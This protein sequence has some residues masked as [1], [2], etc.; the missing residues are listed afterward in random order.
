MKNQLFALIGLGLLLAT[1]SAYAQTGVVK[2]NV[3]FNF[4]VE[5]TQIPAGEYLIQNLG[6]SGSAMTIESPDRKLVKL[7]LP[8][9]C[10]STQA[11]E[12]TK[13]VFHRYADQYFLAQI[14]TEGNN[15][16]L[17]LPK[18]RREREVAMSYPAPKDVVVVA[19]LR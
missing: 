19:T 2:A 14:W 3:P 13:L 1:A 8:N 15:R 11:Q 7:V 17:E 10:E 5:K 18:T 6:T 4:I 16:G 9:D 12:K